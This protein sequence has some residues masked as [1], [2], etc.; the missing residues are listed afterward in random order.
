MNRAGLRPLGWS[1]AR[2]RPLPHNQLPEPDQLKD[3]DFVQRYQLIAERLR[4]A[5]DARPASR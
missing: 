2:P 4:A 5:L 1:L 3:P